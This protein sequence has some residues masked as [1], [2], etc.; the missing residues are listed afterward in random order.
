MLHLH[1]IDTLA[2][3][4]RSQVIMSIKSNIDQLICPLINAAA[5]Q[6]ANSLCSTP[7]SLSAFSSLCREYE[8]IG[9]N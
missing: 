2:E 5:K 8:R 1:R 6:V 9:G 3:L 4:I 7:S